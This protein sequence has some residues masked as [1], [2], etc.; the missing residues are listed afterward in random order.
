M[1]PEPESMNRTTSAAALFQST[2]TDAIPA[3]VPPWLGSVVLAFLVYLPFLGSRA[4]L[5]GH[6]VLLAETARE[7]TVSGDW[8]VP[9]FAGELRLQKPPLGYWL[10]AVSYR[11]LGKAEEFAARLPTALSAVGLVGLIAW[12]AET[13]FDRR[14]GWWSG[15]VLAMAP[16]LITFGKLALIDGPLA[17]LVSAAVALGTVDRGRASIPAARVLLFGMVLGLIVLAKGPVGVLIALP[18]VVAARTLYWRRG[19]GNRFF[20]RPAAV[21]AAILLMMISLAWPVAVAVH[22]PEAW[23]IWREQS[24]GRFLVHYGSSDRPWFYYLYQAPLW[25]LP[26]CCFWILEGWT[27]L[28]QRVQGRVRGVVDDRRVILWTWFAGALVLLSLSAGKR[29]HYV[30]PGL[31]PL[32]ILAALGIDRWTRQRPTRSERLSRWAAVG[33]V[34]VV[35]YD[36]AVFPLFHRRSGTA[37]MFERQSDAIARADQIVQ[38]GNGDRW[39]AFS[40]RKPMRWP[41]TAEETAR[42]VRSGGKVLV[43]VPRCRLEELAAHFPLEILDDARAG[44]GWAESDP[45]YDLVLVR[46][47]RTNRE[48]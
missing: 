18:P 25:T 38:F 42:S 29:E 19:I 27:S 47:D 44:R 17:F 30:L 7:M 10:S 13:W 8:I 12:L 9:R 14:A 32:A 20:A 48:R 5:D 37:A 43:L 40:L 35:A 4:H 39:G 1:H 28:R 22:H 21:L 45:R 23:R 31:P 41:A 11:C 6:E 16:W 15:V 2:W 24:L 33:L 26:A 34:C 36:V 3:R 46:A